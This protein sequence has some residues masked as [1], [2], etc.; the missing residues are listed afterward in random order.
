MK[1]VRNE[2]GLYIQ[3]AALPMRTANDGGL[4]ILLITS[5]RTRR[6]I[7][8][9]GWPIPGLDGPR[10]ATI[11]AFEEAGIKGDLLPQPIGSYRYGKH[12][13]VLA[14]EMPCEVTVYP[15]QSVT[16]LTDWPE[17]STRQLQWFDRARAARLVEETELAALIV[18][19]PSRLSGMSAPL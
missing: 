14:D 13:G 7:I 6:W 12:M 17:R 16:Q 10:T 5:R 8:P 15:M 2:R 9:K 19:V 3:Y 1:F 11:E 4:E 18:N